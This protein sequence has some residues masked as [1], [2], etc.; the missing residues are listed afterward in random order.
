MIL[1]YWTTTTTTERQIDVTVSE[2]LEAIAKS[3]QTAPE[4]ETD[5]EY[6]E[7]VMDDVDMETVLPF[8]EELPAVEINDEN[9]ERTFESWE[10]TE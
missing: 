1:V 2:L 4:R 8:L 10:E 5:S 9:V 3:G 7:R 6:V